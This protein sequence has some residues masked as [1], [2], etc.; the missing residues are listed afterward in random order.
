MCGCMGLPGNKWTNKMNQMEWDRIGCSK[1]SE[2]FMQKF[3]SA[4]QICWNECLCKWLLHEWECLCL[5]RVCVCVRVRLRVSESRFYALRNFVSMIFR[6]E[7]FEH[8]LPF[9]IDLS[10]E[11]VCARSFV[12]VCVCCQV[13]LLPFSHPRGKWSRM[14]LMCVLYHRHEN[15]FNTKIPES[16]FVTRTYSRNLPLGAWYSSVG[17]VCG[18]CFHVETIMITSSGFLSI[19]ILLTVEKRSATESNITN[20]SNNQKITRNTCITLEH[21]LRVRHKLLRFS[22]QFRTLGSEKIIFALSG[23]CSAHTNFVSS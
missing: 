8:R 15:V 17:I 1:E 10:Y 9:H 3:E 22:V 11:R 13:V 21:M 7:K 12:R 18:F 6:C 16:T 4:K 14:K 2:K 5:G 19:V 20:N 23:F